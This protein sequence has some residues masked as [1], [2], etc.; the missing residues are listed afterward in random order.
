MKP[1]D[2]NPARMTVSQSLKTLTQWL[3]GE[4]ENQ[5][6][7][8]DQPVWFVHLR[9]WHRPLP[10]RID[11]KIAIFAEQANVL[12]TENPYRQRVLVFDENEA[13]F[14]KVQYLAFKHPEQFR[15]A[16][17][18]PT[19]LANLSPSDVEF[20]PGCVLNVTAAETAFI[21]Q[22][23]P[24]AKCCFQYQGQTRQ[25]ALGFEV[26]AD[27]F[28]S[29]DKGVDIETGQALWGALM[30]PYDFQ[31]TRDFSQELPLL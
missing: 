17:A 21:A 9:L 30:G 12:K 2:D 15:G 11:G 25:V 18:N 4:F 28:L 6:Q 24:D 23:P 22:M 14:I 29:Y 27:R 8:F 31:K 13:G 7:A 1:S 20:L 19:L 10:H 5:A 16:G 3:A 26:K